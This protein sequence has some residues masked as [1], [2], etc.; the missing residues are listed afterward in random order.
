MRCL[1]WGT[2]LRETS[3]LNIHDCF[4]L[5]ILWAFDEV[6]TALDGT[7]MRTGA[8]LVFWI[9]A[10]PLAV[11]K[12]GGTQSKA[13]LMRGRTSCS[14]IYLLM[15][16][17]AKKHALLYDAVFFCFFVFVLFFFLLCVACLHISEL[18][19]CIH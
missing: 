6:T 5:L 14:W 11:G 13:V 9:K 3:P 8:R 17:F 4:S 7:N 2:G 19:R 15:F 18:S 16:R 12:C 10:V 1:F